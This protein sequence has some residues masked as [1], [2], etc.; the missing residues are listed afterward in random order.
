MWPAS[1]SGVADVVGSA[2]LLGMLERLV[3]DALC[4]GEA[5]NILAT[6]VQC[7]IFDEK[8]TKASFAYSMLVLWEA[9]EYVI[10]Y[11]F[12][13]VER[14]HW[15]KIAQVLGLLRSEKYSID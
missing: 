3:F 12:L 5:K 11:Y 2:E 6:L 15:L 14:V 9:V 13:E 7:G 1:Q 8:I 4:L 10:K